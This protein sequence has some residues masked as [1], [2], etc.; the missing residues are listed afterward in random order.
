MMRTFNGGPL[1]FALLI[2]LG[3]F[4]A[5]AQSESGTLFTLDDVGG[6]VAVFAV[7]PATGARRL[8]VTTDAVSLSDTTMAFDPVTGRLFFRSGTSLYTVDVDAGT[9][10]SVTAGWGPLEFDVAGRQ[11]YTVDGSPSTV[12]ALNPMTGAATVVAVTDAP[13]IADAASAFD[14]A[15]RRFFFRS[16]SELY[17]VNVRTGTYTHVAAPGSVLEFDPVT[18]E[19][20]TLDFVGPVVAVLAINPATGASRQVAVTDAPSNG[21]T[22]A[23]DVVTRRLFFR[24]VGELYTVNVDTGAFTHVASAGFELEFAASHS[25]I[26]A[27]ST[28]MA[29]VL[30]TLLACWGVL[31]LR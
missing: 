12:Y 23:F 20:Y 7:E 15:Q 26:P 22:I 21:G 3:S 19:I 6:N 11:L 25:N 8:I 9:Y 27:L 17:T 2:L 4:E 13:S 14:Q 16:G 29:L 18:G 24:S 30:T 1:L 28:V 31:K 5:A 10:S